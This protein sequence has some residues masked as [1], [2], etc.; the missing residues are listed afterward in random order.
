MCVACQKVRIE[1]EASD[2][3]VF[4]DEVS[5]GYGSLDGGTPRA[6]DRLDDDEYDKTNDKEDDNDDAGPPPRSANVDLKSRKT[7]HL[8]RLVVHQL[9][10]TYGVNKDIVLEAKVTPKHQ[11]ATYMVSRVL[12][13]K[14]DN[15]KWRIIQSHQTG[16]TAYVY[17]KMHKS[18]LVMFDGK[19]Y[20]LHLSI[21]F[22]LCGDV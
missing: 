15:F 17:I 3:E 2:E 13:S 12:F 22:L 19:R 1:E 14:L 16:D 4:D 21:A 18:D 7:V 9:R 5:Y 20:D 11:E 10:V 6:Y 8:S